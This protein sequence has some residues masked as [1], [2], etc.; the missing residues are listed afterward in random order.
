MDE[1]IIL[2]EGYSNSDKK[3]VALDFTPEDLK[4]GEIITAKIFTF[5]Q[6]A[7][8]YKARLMS[9]GIKCFLTNDKRIN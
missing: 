5:D 7:Q 2:D 4:K 8:F 1:N 9:E 6:K 3:K